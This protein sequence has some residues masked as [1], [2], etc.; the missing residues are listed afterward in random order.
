[1][2]RI[3]FRRALP[4]LLTLFHGAFVWSALSFQ[5]HALRG[6]QAVSHY[7]AVSYQEDVGVP[8]DSIERPPLKPIQKMAL[9]VELPA[10]LFAILI[11][12]VVLHQ[13]EAAWMYLSI[14][15]VPFLWYVIGRWLDGLLGYVARLRVPR[16][17]RGSLKLAAM[18]V[19]VVS[20]A[21]FTPLYRHRTADTYWV[22]T[23]LVL[24]SGLCVAIMFTSG[25]RPTLD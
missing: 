20:L 15:L 21:G 25:T 8:M 3:G 24:W 5:F 6:Q 11:G 23:G 19:L 7:K 4:V 22:F 18:F 10:M 9:I 1:M 2:R 14:P 16:I 17:L 12:T 13:N